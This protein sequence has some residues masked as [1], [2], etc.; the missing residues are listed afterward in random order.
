MKSSIILIVAIL[1]ISFQTNAQT[2]SQRSSTTGL[3][4]GVELGLF[5]YAL[6]DER[7]TASTSVKAKL[8]Y[9]I[10]EM[11]SVGLNYLHSF[12]IEQFI[13]PNFSANVF[14]LEGRINFGSTQSVLR[15]TIAANLSYSTSDPGLLEGDYHRMSLLKGFGFGVNAGL[16]YFLNTAMSISGNADFITGRYTDNVFDGEKDDQNYHFNLLSFTIG[17]NYKIN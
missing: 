4:G 5:S 11:F 9:G 13:E 1:T 3:T 6:D 16:K 15:P 12:N 8:N 14:Q 17:F 2:I 10:D 7:H